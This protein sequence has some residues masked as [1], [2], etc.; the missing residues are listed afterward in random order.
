MSSSKRHEER[1]KGKIITAKDKE[2]Q[3]EEKQKF[4]TIVKTYLDEVRKASTS[5]SSSLYLDPEHG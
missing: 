3:N 5:E 4:D 2:K 1:E